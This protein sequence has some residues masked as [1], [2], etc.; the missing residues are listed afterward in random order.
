MLSS[1]SL[2]HWAV[3]VA[4]ICAGLISPAPAAVRVDPVTRYVYVGYR[5]PLD[6]PEQ[7]A[8]LCTWSP[9][10]KNDW[11]PAKVTPLVSDTAMKLVSDSEWQAWVEQGKI[12]E[13]RAAGLDRTAVFNPYPDAEEGGRV[14][15]DFK[16]TVQ[17]LEGQAIST[18]VARIQADNS[19]VVGVEDWSQVLQKDALSTEPEPAGRKWSWRTGLEASAGASL[20]NELYGQGDAEHPLHSLTFPL[21]L[22]GW[23][24]IYVCNAP[25]KG[26]IGLR[27]TG[28]ERTDHAF[29]RRPREEVLWRWARMDR[30]HLILKQSHAYTGWSAAHIDYARFVPLTNELVEQLEAPYAGAKDKFVAAYFEPY[31][32]AFNE[33][34]LE[35]LQHREPLTAYQEAGVSL[36]DAQIGRFGMKV[37]YESRKTDPL[38]YATIGDPIG[39]VAQP[40]TDNVGR[41]QQYTNT[42]DAELRYARELG[43]PMHAN[44][45]AS[46]CY[47]GTPLQGD[48]S[49][50]HP[51][52][53]RGH[54]LRFEVPDVRAYAFSL[55]REALETGAPGVSLDFCRYPETIDKAETCN[56][57][58]S[59]L[60]K[61]ADEF[62]ASRG[63]RVPILVRFPGTGVR[64]WEM[65]DYRTWVKERWVD[66]LCPSNIQGRHIHIDAAPYLEA[67]RGSSS[68]LLPVVDGLHWG[69]DRPG[70]F[71]WRVAKL[72]EAGVDGIYV[73]QA[74]DPCLGWPAD[75]R[76]MR[77][78]SSSEAVRKWWDE[79][80]RLRP[81]RS[82][83]IYISR[84]GAI[85]GYHGWE[86]LRVWLEGIEMGPVEMYLDDKL[87]NRADGPPYLLGAE[88]YESDSVI[89]P[90]D[91][92]LRVR[93][94]D[95]GGWLE[96]TFGI[97]SGG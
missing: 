89:P 51:D 46:N 70:P 52:W 84:Q 20:G 28:D 40:K 73:Y 86:R 59:E 34:V 10:G 69:P 57:F 96:Q 21:D 58:L 94:K 93:A 39:N 7:V 36:V 37:V 17:T 97:K 22:H 47:I 41:M 83:G 2:A 27:L 67:V 50:Q 92:T 18:S 55:Y 66:Y 26:G 9:A 16:V 24:A 45:G 56:I 60:R 68:K 76:M 19:D 81:A 31:S 25:A 88:A 12:V 3:F 65:F 33:K 23:Y 14:D 87:V 61:L 35:P 53:V 49:K 8:V 38:Y 54:A 43:L 91:H 64:Q 32:W 90:G 95:G 30:Q 13:R 75:R 15:A 1:L 80:R 72:Y 11:R 42:L 77:L 29:S 78:L 85:D 79:D 62:S 6:A 48:F 71:L 4:A 82:K 5:V 74:D 44:F 63:E